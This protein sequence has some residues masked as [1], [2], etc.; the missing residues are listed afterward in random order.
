[1]VLSTDNS[2]APARV[3]CF[4]I[5]E[6]D[7]SDFHALAAEVQ[8][9]VLARLEAMRTI[10]AA[11]SVR[12]GAIRVSQSMGGIRGWS[13]ARL[14]SQWSEFSVAGT[15]RAL[16]NCAKAGPAHYRSAGHVEDLPAAS[17]PAF[18]EFVKAEIERCQR[19]GG[20][21]YRSLLSRWARWNAG[22]S[23]AA[24][25]GYSICPPP[26][27]HGLHPVGWGRDNIMRMSPD[28][29]DLTR[30]RQG[31]RAASHFR[32]AVLTTRFGVSVGEYLQFDDVEFDLRVN[33][34]GQPQAMRPR[35]FFALDVLS[36][37]DVGMFWKPTLWDEEASK[38]KTLT[39]RDFL[40]FV[41]HT[42]MNCGYRSDHLGTQLIW[43]HGTA[44]VRD[45][46]FLS[47][48]EQVTGGRV[49]RA[50]SGIMGVEQMAGMFEG[51]GRGNF[52]FKS[53]RESL[54]GL[55]HNYFQQLPG[56]VGLSRDRSPEQLVGLERYNK[57]ILAL[58]PTLSPDRAPDLRFPVLSWDQF[59][60]AALR[61][62]D[63]ISTRTDH[64]MEGWE[65][66]GFV[67]TFWRIADNQQWISEDEFAA[68]T[69][70]QRAAITTLV[71]SEP[72]RFRQ[73][74][75][76]SPRQVFDRSR[77]ELTRIRH[78]QLPVLLSHRAE[79]LGREVTVRRGMITIDSEEFGPDPIHFQAL[80]ARRGSGHR[81]AEGS[82]FLAF[83]NPIAPTH[84]VACD[85]AMKIS[86]ICQFWDRPSR[87]NLDAVGAMMGRQRKHENA[88]HR[89]QDARHSGFAAEH[90]RM[91]KH[92]EDVAAGLPTTPEDRARA[93]DLAEQ[94]EAHGAEA[95]ADILSSPEA[96][97]ES[98][99]TGDDISGEDFLSDISTPRE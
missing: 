90:A 67:Q 47:T 38:K 54:F 21:A 78:D 91:L 44:T 70:V 71:S 68:Y 28:R 34:P 2:T 8:R 26:A 46:S 3:L 37:C 58:V 5:P 45:R 11:R 57:Q 59:N 84:L 74:R 83:L 20:Q 93:R 96:P 7:R 72:S 53:H 32:P 29:A 39:E 69:E 30:A 88:A 94:V 79:E 41:I 13:P 18:R 42:M 48:L 95:V 4:E 62:L 19:N 25:P 10:S 27:A 89:D 51:T 49:R 77:H 14:R 98:P 63:Q 43:E 85:S 36:A 6:S 12:D 1:M 15:W 97:I 50:V 22:E 9:D 81:L 16:L 33:F 86:A 40:W 92:N 82:K 52:R 76:M 31:Q 23:K 87:N 64:E 99:A 65:R 80:D 66:C 35:G 24:I 56:Q 55:L 73:L 60:E 17:N 61:L 75:K